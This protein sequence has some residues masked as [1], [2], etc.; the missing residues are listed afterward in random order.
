MQETVGKMELG[1]QGLA[2]YA[3]HIVLRD[4]GG[5]GQMRLLASRVLVIGAGGI[6]SP[7]A[8]YLAAAGVGHLTI[9][10]DDTVS[11]SNLQRQILHRN[12]DIGRAKTDSAVDALK[13]LNPD[14]A[15]VGRRL[16]LDADNARPLIADHDIVLDG[17]DNFA[18]RLAVNAAAVAAERTLVSAALGPFEGQLAVFRG[19]LPGAPCYRCFLGTEP[20]R[21]AGQSCA[22][23]GILGAVAGVMGSWAAL[24]TLREILAIGDSLA[25]RMLLF[26]AR[27]ASTR[28]VR[29]RP[30]PA[31]PVCAGEAS[32]EGKR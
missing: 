4:V 32:P 7:A 28:I 15:V 12:A 1:E 3:R 31:C 16:R 26:D 21:E 14:I 18:T 2:R 22:E 5:P 17:S 6:G 30:D 11:L 29:L 24:E 19:H 10:D 27:S 25:G 20:P 13:A 8:L 23:L 9:V